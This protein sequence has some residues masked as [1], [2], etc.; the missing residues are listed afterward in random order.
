MEAR[1]TTGQRQVLYVGVDMHKRTW[2]VTGVHE[3]GSEAFSV[4][5]R[6]EA[7]ELLQY[8]RKWSDRRIEVV[9]EAGYFG[10]GLHD[11][12]EEHGITC[13]VTPPSLIPGEYGNRVKTDQRDSRKL[14][15]LL[16][17][18]LLKRVYVLTP[19][20]RAHRQVVR[21]RRTFMADRRRKQCQIKAFLA[22]YGVPLPECTGPWTRTFVAH[23]HG[24]RFADRWLQQCF[25]RLMRAFEQA[26][27]LVREQTDMIRTLAQEESYRERVALLCL[28]PGIGL[29]TAMELL[30]ELQEIERFRTGAHIAAYVGLTPSQ[31][32]SGDRI[33]MGHITRVGKAHLR[34]ALIEAAW[35]LVRKDRRAAEMF[36][37]IRARAGAKRAIVAIA[38]RLLLLIRSV[39]ITGTAYV[40]CEA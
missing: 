27:L 12:L 39:L 38:R 2:H 33:R 37:T 32:S 34:G 1:E 20:E 24:I 29:L 9:Y 11:E 6:A 17:K 36:A 26:D 16:A 14:A 30:V 7:A 31:F 22:Q 35:V 15:T 28:I 13:T 5:M 40:P 25:A 10:Y 18:G 4:S 23:L 19:R 21:S 3:R 8:L